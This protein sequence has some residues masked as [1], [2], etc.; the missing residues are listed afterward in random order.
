MRVTG[1]RVGWRGG[2]GGTKEST[3]RDNKTYL[4]RQRPVV[5]GYFHV[6]LFIKPIA[7][8]LPKGYGEL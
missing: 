8:T 7:T 4:S 3:G 1:E 6:L 5:G 2:I